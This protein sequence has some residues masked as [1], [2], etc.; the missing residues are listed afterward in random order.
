MTCQH[1]HAS[2]IDSVLMAIS[3]IEAMTA[4]DQ[5]RMVEI[6]K[7]TCSSELA[8]GLAQA[9]VVLTRI[10]SVASGVTAA[11]VLAATRAGALTAG[12][13]LDDVKKHMGGQS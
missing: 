3:F 11:Q 10:A 12:S 2:P 8:A 6:A 4:G 7:S 9:S 13:F 1:E 5:P